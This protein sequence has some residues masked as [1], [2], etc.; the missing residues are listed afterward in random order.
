M[1][2]FIIKSYTIYQGINFPHKKCKKISRKI[3]DFMHN[4]AL[5]FASIAGGVGD[6]KLGGR[7]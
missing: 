5:N 4:Q 3:V 7:N 2:F 6:P 1:I